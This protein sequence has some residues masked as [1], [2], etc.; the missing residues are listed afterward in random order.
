MQYIDFGSTTFE[1]DGSAVKY[2]IVTTGY[3]PAQAFTINV[4]VGEGGTITAYEIVANGSTSDRFTGL[5][6]ENVKDGS[7]FVGK[8][9]DEI[10]SLLSLNDD[11]S[12]GSVDGSLTTGATYSNFLCTYAALFAAANYDIALGQA[13]GA[14]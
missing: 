11:G 8:G 6:P 14:Q 3:A 12:F 9:A 1:A 4:T 5:M 2:S 10:L 13:G 7:L